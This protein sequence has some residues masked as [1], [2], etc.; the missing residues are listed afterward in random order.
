MVTTTIRPLPYGVRPLP[1][2]DAPFGWR[3]GYENAL[4]YIKLIDQI[5]ELREAGL[6][7]KADK[8]SNFLQVSQWEWEDTERRMVANARHGS[9]H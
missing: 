8:V 4:S 6:L 7:A 2:V 1:S 9:I 5:R 3:H